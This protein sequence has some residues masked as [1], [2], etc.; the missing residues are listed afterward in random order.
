[1]TTGNNKLRGSLLAVLGLS[2][3][4]VVPSVAVKAAE[5]GPATA[6][7]EIIVTAR[8]REESSQK[9]PEAVS[10]ISAKQLDQSF[11]N[12]GSGL[13]GVSPNLVFDRVVS[14]P[15]GAAL[16]IRGISFQDI[17]KSFDPAV[18]VALDGIYLGTNTG[19]VFQIFDFDRIEVLRG[20]QGTLFGKNTIGGI[21]NIV[22]TEPT[23]EWGGKFRIRGGS[24]DHRDFDGLL[25][26]PLVADKFSAKLNFTSRKQDG[27][28][29]N[30]F[31]GG[32]YTGG[33]NYKSYGA[34]FKWTPTDDIK[35]LYTYQKEKDKSPI[36]GLINISLPTDLLCAALAQCAQS[37]DGTVSQN[38]D[39]LLVNQNFSNQQFYN[40]NGHT[41]S[42]KWQVADGYTFN[43]ILGIRENKEQTHQD[44]DSSPVDFYQTERT[45]NYKQTSNE[46][47][48][49]YDKGGAF[50]LVTGVYTW[51][52]HYYLHQNTYNFF[53]I[54][55]AFGVLPFG[56]NASPIVYGQDT[57]HSTKSWAVF[58]QSDYKFTDQWILTVG[59][60]YTNEKKQL[61]SRQDYNFANAITNPFDS[62]GP[63]VTTINAFNTWG[64]PAEKSWSK[65]TP[66]VGLR[67][68]FTPEQMAYVSFSTGFRSGGFNGRGGSLDAVTVPYNPE[69]V[70][71]VEVGYKS[72]W[73]DDHLRFNIDV[74][75]SKYKDKQEEIVVLAPNGTNQTLVQ[76]AS[77]ATYKGVE[78]ELSAIPIAG[79][80]LRFTGGYL[81]AKYDSFC[82]DLDGAGASATAPGQCATATNLGGGQFLV[83]TD[84]SYL[85]L[86]RAPKYTFSLDST[87]DW[88]MGPGEA[89]VNAGVRYK[90]KYYTTFQTVPAGLTDSA[91]IV[92]ASASYALNNWR[93][94]VYGHNLTDKVVRNSA[95]LVA[96]LFSFATSTLPREYGAEIQYKFGAT[97]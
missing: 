73:L 11:Q 60:R 70:D 5:A 96:G 29:R 1:M 34:T 13:E 17:E 93:F 9:V 64:A 68:Q 75:H 88:T 82:A 80:T 81:D 36:G 30:L 12:A 50:N 39:P 66:K 62:A 58:A 84:N 28:E 92:D 91:A 72:Q 46:L 6:L 21:I 47:R 49:T 56:P 14:G 69:K 89:T 52:A 61:E 55:N 95:L 23:G 38:G 86:R 8:K 87:Y 83:P 48:F 18:G 15:G 67:Y 53:D 65:F 27:A 19:Q 41:L 2:A 32:K 37:P 35:V 4:S 45:Q 44:F 7:E 63:Q 22:R 94:S 85:K 97:K 33:T 51:R 24:R 25:D 79:W 10:A 16:S 26:V 74:F 77:Q 71:S 43:Y 54:L 31:T 90:D 40:L 59:G 78:V 3:G 20:P 42:A 57:S 76:N